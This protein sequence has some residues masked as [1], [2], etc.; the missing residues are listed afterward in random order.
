[1]KKISNKK[2]MSRLKKNE[3]FLKLDEVAHSCRHDIQ[4]A[5]VKG[6]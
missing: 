4:E 5:K 1:M 2:N 3:D 6:L